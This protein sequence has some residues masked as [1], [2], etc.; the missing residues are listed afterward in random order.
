M[1]KK[2]TPL[3]FYAK[4]VV[5]IQDEQDNDVELKHGVAYSEKNSKLF[6]IIFDF[7]VRVKENNMLLAVKFVANFSCNADIDNEFK[8]SDFVSVNAPAIA[9]PYLRALVSQF[10][11][12][13]GYEP[14]VLP[15]INF[16]ALNKQ[17]DKN[18]VK[19]SK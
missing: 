7:S 5:F 9:Y 16:V 3:N 12:L 17:R 19:Q 14:I 2:I 13:T 8:Q 15:V 18:L 11:L 1:T 4:S 6:S 10:L